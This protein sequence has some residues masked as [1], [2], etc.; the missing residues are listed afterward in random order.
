MPTV[1]A[2][3]LSLYYESMGRDA[4]PVI[5]L[6]MGLAMQLTMW[7]DAFCERLV[8]DGFRV[9]RFDNR[10]VGL[11]THL[12]HLGMPNLPLEYLRYALRRPLRSPYGIHDMADDTAALIDALALG[13]VHIV[14]AS[15]G[16]M[17]AQNVAARFP[18]K[19][20]SLTSIMSS[21]AKRSVP[22]PSWRIRLAMMRRPGRNFTECVD[23]MVA[24]QKLLASRT[25]PLD[26]ADLRRRCEVHVRRDSDP[27]GPARQVIAIAACGDRTM[28]ARQIRVPTLV[29]HGD[30]DPLIPVADGVETASLIRAGGG[31]ARLKIF[32]GMGHDFPA[33]LIPAIAEEIA[34]HCRRNTVRST[35]PIR[36]SV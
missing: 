21:S 9:V 23:R 11:S 35:D 8:A 24:T 4:D 19:L 25:L 12:D 18:D 36:G 30:E 5:L 1:S 26:E 17:I 16:G 29:I 22:Q 15:M 32:K 28:I 6:V 2:N 31:D 20:A 10:D 13:G 33:S 14:G 7:P 3:G 27:A 34:V